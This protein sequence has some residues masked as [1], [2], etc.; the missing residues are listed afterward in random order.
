MAQVMAVAFEPMG[1]LYYVD[2]NGL[3][4]AHG[5]LVLVPTGEGIEVARCIWGPIERDWPGVLLK[6]AGLADPEALQRDADNRQWR[7]RILVVAKKLIR[8]H[9]LRMR[10]VGVDF[11]DQSEQFDRQAV[12]YFESPRRVDFRALVHDLARAL[13]ARIDLRQIGVRDAAAIIGG[14]GGCGRELCCA[15]VQLPTPGLTVEVARC[16][17]LSG[18][19]SQALGACG[20][21]MCCLR[22]EQEQYRQYQQVAPRIGAV[23]DT[24]AGPGRV[25]GHCVPKDAVL[26][27]IGDGITQIPLSQLDTSGGPGS[28]PG[29][30]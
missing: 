7:A 5:Q 12:V 26:V 29:G 22:Y 3:K 9:G 21:L 17:N 16:Q 14:V 8:Q 6:C 4:V 19:G 24:P 11:V 2:P 27:E 20:R 13:S 28:L 1:R 25:S 30:G 15:T 18:A 23:V 10:V